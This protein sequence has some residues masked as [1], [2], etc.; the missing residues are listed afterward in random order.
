MRV[1]RG[2]IVGGTA[3]R[4]FQGSA[5]GVPATPESPEYSSGREKYPKVAP[6]TEEC[7]ESEDSENRVIGY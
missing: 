7:E 3:L 5:W 2:R 1:W 4:C 6:L